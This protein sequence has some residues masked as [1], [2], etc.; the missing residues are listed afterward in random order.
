MMWR[1][2]RVAGRKALVTGG[3]GGYIALSLAQEGAD[4]AVHYYQNLTEA[5]RVAREIQVPKCRSA[6]VQAAIGYA[7]SARS[8]HE[9]ISASFGPFDPLVDCAGSTGTASSRT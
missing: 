8:M 6:A 9:K 1:E 4:V 7:E 5:Q 2:G 3:L